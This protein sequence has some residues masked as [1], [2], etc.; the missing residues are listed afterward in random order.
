LATGTAKAMAQ[1]AERVTVL[2]KFKG[3]HLLGY[4]Q[5]HSMKPAR[6]KRAKPAPRQE[7][8]A[9]EASFLKPAAVIFA[10]ALAVR[11]FHDWQISHAPFFAVLMGDAR[12]Y[13]EW[14]RQ[15]AAG[16][17]IGKDVFYQA[18]LYPYFLGVIYALFGHSLVAVRVVQA[19]LGST[20]CVLLA[21]AAR[22]LFSSRA[23]LAAGLALALYAPA[24]FFD[25]LIQKSVLD[26]FLICVSL[27]LLS[28]L[29]ERA[30]QTFSWLWLGMALGALALTRENALV[31]IAV[32]AVWAIVR[33]RGGA[34]LA[35]LA[36]FALGLAVFL[37]PVAVRN[38]AVGGG[39]YLTTSQ[40]GPNFYIGNNARADGTYAPL[41]EGR[42]TPEYER[43]DATDI[44]EH[45][46][47]H[48]LTPGDVSSYWTGEA[49]RF[50]ASQPG[51]WTKLMARKVVLLLNHTEAVDT[52]SQETYAEWSL[53]L[54]ALGWVGHFGVL[55]PLALF[56]CI[57]AWPERKRLWVLYALTAAY[58]ASVLMF[59]VFAR[60]RFPLV[61]M[62][63][64]F[65]AAGL[66]AI[67][68]YLRGTVPL[69][70]KAA[71]AVALVAVA[72]FSN[73]P[74]LSAA[75]MQ[76]VTENNLGAAL[77]A[78]GKLDAAIEHYRRALTMRPG[79]APAYNNLGAAL[80][81]KGDT[82]GAIA[83][84]RQA[85][86]VDP[87][88]AS[89][90]F[91][92]A[93]ALMDERQLDEAIAQFTIA[94]KATPGSADV[95]NN[96]GIALAAKG[97]DSEAAAAFRQALAA[98]PTSPQAHKNLS[99]MLAALGRNDEAI[100]EL[101][102][103]TE[104]APDDASLHYDLATT[105]LEAKKL[106]EAAAEFRRTIALQPDMVEAHNNLGATLV[107]L[108]KPDEGIAEFQLALKLQPGDQDARRNLADALQLKK[109][110]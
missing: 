17:W 86:A 43:Q 23:G 5:S 40:F 102:R 93:N 19:F 60:Y 74:V 104:L 34:L 68:S 16:D 1:S 7:L 9:T 69:A 108:G 105:L 25:G 83:A 76:A 67:P 36:T 6:P 44:A 65:A 84:Y 90:H 89:A 37:L 98:D 48:P 62:L 50:I 35:P 100:A 58:A 47:G 42:G 64:L 101:A 92:L 77:Q 66:V 41:K 22:R 63:I 26:V 109:R 45:A 106:P 56:G 3:F 87:G 94:A 103:A 57:V 71:V 97:R 49:L 11:L 18:P 33:L 15:L 28:G 91:N 13:D 70:R 52:E 85:L 78:D 30:H 4:S 80:R 55:V 21:L 12:G 72:V 31:L 96:L 81:A 107:Y 38:Y 79:D 75:S 46:A 14:A 32:I 10:V 88:Y 39:F 99:E 61:P 59:Y 27:W 8:P 51:A 29:V 110:P 73:W 20:A 24:I 82:S 2:F 53:P 54:E 95:L